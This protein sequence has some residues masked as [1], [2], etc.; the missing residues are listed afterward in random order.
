MKRFDR[1]WPSVR[2]QLGYGLFACDPSLRVCACL[3]GWTIRLGTEFKQTMLAE[4][5]YWRDSARTGSRDLFGMPGEWVCPLCPTRKFQRFDR[6]QVHVAKYHTEKNYGIP[7]SVRKLSRVIV[8]QHCHSTLGAT[9][10][11]LFRGASLPPASFPLHNAALAIRRQLE[12]SP[13]WGERCADLDAVGTHIDEHTAILL[14]LEKTRFILREDASAHHRISANYWAT[15]RFLSA[16]LAAIIHPDT[17]AAHDRVMN[18]LR[19]RSGWAGYLF[20]SFRPIYHTLLEELLGHDC[21]QECMRDCRRQAD[22]SVLSVDGSYKP[23]LS[24]LYQT[25]FGQRADRPVAGRIQPLH[26][27][28]SVRCFDSV[29]MPRWL[30][31]ASKQKSVSQFGA[32]AACLKFPQGFQRKM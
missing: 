19:D 32:V 13:S 21:I 31:S 22:K 26:V 4:V 30:S 11:G 8:A 20:P 27:V 15:D 17:K 5:R 28:I 3:V 25:P 18:F 24:V 29:C 7:P 6:L 14:D 16:F 9:V 1:T 10:L 12:S 2:C 23:L